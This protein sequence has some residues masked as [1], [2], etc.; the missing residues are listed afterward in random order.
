MLALIALMLAP[1]TSCK[2][3]DPVHDLAWE[4]AW[5]ECRE[6]I[7]REV[8]SRPTVGDVLDRGLRHLR[9]RPQ[10]AAFSKLGYPDQKMIVAK[11][12]IY[13]WINNYTN[14]DGSA[15]TCT[16]KV[17]VRQ[18]LVLNT[19]FH[20]NSGACDYYARKFDPSFKLH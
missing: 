13:S 2:P 11:S 9:G 17:I 12:V 4:K 5:Q 15:L 18:G 19:E 14:R 20:G 6:Q 10:S 7:D 3:I 1:A 16:V 8:A